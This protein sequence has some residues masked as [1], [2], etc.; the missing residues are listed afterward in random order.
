M[1]LNTLSIPTICLCAIA[2][3]AA[4]ANGSTVAIALPSWDAGKI[5]AYDLAALVEEN[6]D[7]SVEFTEMEGDAIWPELASPDGKIDVFP[8]IWLPNQ[9]SFFDQY[10]KEEGVVFANS[11]PYNGDQGFYALMPDAL[12][13]KKL[14]IKD[15]LDPQVFRAFDTDGNGKGE[16]WPGAEG[17]HSTLYS[18]V[19]IK[20]YGLDQAWELIEGDNDHLQAVVDERAEKSQGL[21]FYYWE[22]EAMFAK[23]PSVKV[24]EVAYSEGCQN[25]VEPKDDEDWLKKSSFK[26]AYEVAT[27]HILFNKEIATHATLGPIFDEYVVDASKLQSAMLMLKENKVDLTGAAKQLR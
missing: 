25:F 12:T 21:L 18:M 13:A 11:M 9:Q 4:V 2:P 5:I 1:R 20:D 19:K 3:Y 27:I 16:L 6:S 26:C 7:F 15:L 17:W 10:V 24:D 14:G 8:D 22:P 23:Y